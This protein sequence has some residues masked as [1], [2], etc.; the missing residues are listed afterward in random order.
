VY[1]IFGSWAVT[2]DGLEH[3]TIPPYFIKAD[4][5]W[6]GEGYYPWERHMAGKV[7]VDLDDFEAAIAAAREF[8]A[9]ARG[10]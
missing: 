5:L 9:G 2:S 6:D 1:E 8:H 4:R 7:W 3:L 10:G